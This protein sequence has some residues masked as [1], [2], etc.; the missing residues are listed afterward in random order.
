MIDNTMKTMPDLC[1]R[2]TPFRYTTAL[3][4]LMRL[5]V[6]I[7]NIHLLAVGEYENYKGEIRE[8]TPKPGTPLLPDTQITLKVGA[9]SPVDFMPYQF[10]F[11]LQN[12]RPSDMSWEEAARRLMAPFD[13]TVVRHE[14]LAVHHILK[15]IGGVI[16]ISYLKKFLNLFKFVPT[17]YVESLRELLFWTSVFPTFN[18]W[19]GNP[20]LVSRI[21]KFIFGFDFEIIENVKTTYEIPEDL[22]YRLGSSGMRLGKET[23]I[24][25]R[26]TELDSS[27]K[28]VVRNVPSSQLTELFP[29]GKLR[30]KLE[31]VLSFC[32]PGNFDF[33]VE[34]KMDRKEKTKSLRLG[35]N[36]FVSA[37]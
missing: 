16:D 21:L 10:F 12:N 26:F 9:P 33:K 32:M 36:S 1:N 24:G 6:D 13:A 27:Y 3:N 35:Y 30:K 20:K 22:Q 11:G 4:L 15:Y 29:G 14:A 25:R 37:T 7:H 18:Y 2:R 28:V 31:W 23:I 17:E 5:G 8:Q 34:I 19:A